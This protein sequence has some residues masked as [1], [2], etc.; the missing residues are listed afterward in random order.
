MT[1][2]EPLDIR[3]YLVT[4]G[5]DR[6]TVETAARAAAAGAGMVQVRAKQLPTAELL[7]LLTVVAEAVHRAAP[8][9]R[10]VVD[11]RADVAFA[12]M[13]AG[14]PVHG[15]HLGWDD[16][17]VEAARAML[18]P[19]AIIGLTTGTADLV[20]RADALSEYI[21]YLGCG[22][23]RPTPTKNSGRTPLGV[24]GY[25]PLVAETRLPMVAIGDVGPQD[26]PALAA[27]GVAGV[28]VVRAIMTA[29]HPEDVVHQ[30]LRAFPRP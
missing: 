8:A 23:F 16:L 24:E 27:T 9:T 5:T 12:A 17:P 13:H 3:C 6:H 10:V 15:V 28:A 7:A 11:D 1:H 21:D 22:P 26:A 19:D 20:R 14:T 4:S 25:R 2:T 29:D 30:I 18:G